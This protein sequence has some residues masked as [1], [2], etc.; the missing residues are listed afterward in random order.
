MPD[1]GSLN[2]VI[3]SEVV[4][5]KQGADKLAAI[6]NQTDTVDTPQSRATVRGGI[7]VDF[8]GV[9]RREIS[10]TTLVTKAVNDK[11]II[12]RTKN[13]ITSQLPYNTFTVEG[14]SIANTAATKYTS[15]FSAKVINYTYTAAEQGGFIANVRLLV[16][17]Y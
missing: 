2:N 1:I 15:T 7:A 8:D 17:A 16:K 13:A 6:Y 10:F 14:T 4:I 11:F 5:L 12:W 3:N 9:Q